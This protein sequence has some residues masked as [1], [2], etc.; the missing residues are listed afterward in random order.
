MAVLVSLTQLCQ[1]MSDSNTVRVDHLNDLIDLRDQ[2]FISASTIF[3]FFTRAACRENLHLTLAS[4]ILSES[5]QFGR[6]K[7]ISFGLE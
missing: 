5:P 6:E 7:K 2:I 3:P 4:V 1:S